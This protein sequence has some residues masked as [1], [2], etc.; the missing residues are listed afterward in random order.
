MTHEQK[1]PVLEL[2][3]ENK[4]EDPEQLRRAFTQLPEEPPARDETLKELVAAE[5]GK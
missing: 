1:A 4:H 2:V 3:I 5:V